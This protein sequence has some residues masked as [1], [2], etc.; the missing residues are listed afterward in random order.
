MNPNLNPINVQL[1][2]VF[3]LYVLGSWWVGRLMTILLKNDELAPATSF[4]IGPAVLALQLWLYGVIHVHWSI[5]TL[6]LPWL[7]VTAVYLLQSSFRRPRW[8]RPRLR[9]N[10]INLLLTL[11]T[12]IT[13]AGG[14]I[15]VLTQPLVTWDA[16]AMWVYKARLFAA[17]QSVNLTLIA[18]DP[19]R[20]LD[21]PPL[22]PLMMD[23]VGTI[24]V[25][26]DHQLAGY[27]FI[28]LKAIDFNFY[29]AGVVGVYL[30]VKQLGGR[31]V[32]L[33]GSYL[34][35]SLIFFI[36]DLF[37]DQY[38]G[39]ADFCF[40]I[41]LMFVVIYSYRAGKRRSLAEAWWVMV[42]AVMAALIKNEGDGVLVAALFVIL[43]L[44][45]RRP[46]TRA[47]RLWRGAIGLITLAPLLAW[48]VIAARHH[49]QS[50]LLTTHNVVTG[51]QHLPDRLDIIAN[52]TATAVITQP[53]LSLLAVSYAAAWYAAARFQSRALITAIGVVTVELGFYVFA[54]V[55]TPYPLV[56]FMDDSFGR[57]V[58]QVAP[59]IVLLVLV[60][61]CQGSRRHSDLK[62][63]PV[64]D[65]L[66]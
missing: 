43:S 44:W 22:F 40:A 48:K 13:V 30:F 10:P 31:R 2:I 26:L 36:P 17:S 5:Y 38:L 65:K 39:Y 61:L 12:G 41:T 14:Y 54:Y 46:V 1:L 21:Y 60:A 33:V 8:W 37:N 18:H 32:G 64:T 27:D 11:L 4:I 35:A 50:D 15:R 7:A 23:S 19:S 62:R 57:L 51:L 45:G 56:S 6:L 47:K 34:L 66:N 3:G 16:V 59:S 29:L 52:Y 63:P 20:H 9:F 49:Y 53:S 58:L 24:V 55:I 42:L 25:G 28:Y